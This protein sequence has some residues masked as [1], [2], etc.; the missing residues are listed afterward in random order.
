[1]VR[2]RLP[3]SWLTS[4]RCLKVNSQQWR[5]SR[6]CCVACCSGE[7]MLLSGRWQGQAAPQAAE[8]HI[9]VPP[10]GP[11][12]AMRPAPGHRQHSAPPQRHQ[13]CTCPERQVISLRSKLLPK[14]YRLQIWGNLFKCAPLL[15]C[16]FVSCSDLPMPSHWETSESSLLG[17]GECL[18]PIALEGIVGALCW[19]VLWEI[20]WRT[21]AHGTAVLSCNFM[22]ASSRRKSGK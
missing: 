8:M 18:S 11:G 15:L 5:G 17:V 3:D 14:L 9:V 7:H 6:S 1:M 10:Q 16:Y 12:H 13:D 19:A 22:C 21:R 20:F 4:N 2:A